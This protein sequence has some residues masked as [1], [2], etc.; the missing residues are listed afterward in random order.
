MA[1]CATTALAGAVPRPCVRGAR[2]RFGGLGPAPGVV[3]PPFPPSRP[4]C[5]ALCV[6][7]RPVRVSLTSLAGNAIARGLCVPRA[8]SGCSSGSP[9][10]PFVCVCAR[11]PAAPVSPPP[12]GCVACAPRAVPVLGAGRAVPRGPCPSACPAPVPCSV[13]RAGEGGRPGPGLP[14]PGLGLCAPR[15]VGLRIRGVAVPLGGVG[16]GG[17][18]PCATPPV[19]AVGGASGA[20]G[21]SASFRPSA[22]PGQATKRATLASFWSWRAWPP[23]RSGSCSP[24]FSGRGLCRVLARWGG[25][26]CSLPFLWEPAAWGGGRR[27][28]LRPLSRAPRSRRGG[29]GS[30]P[31]PREGGRRRPRGLRAGGGAG[32]GGGGRHGPPSLPLGGGP[33][34]PTLPPFSSSAHSPPACA[35]SRGRRAAPC[36]GCG[37][38]GGGGGEEGRP[39]DRSPGGPFRHKTCLCPPQVGNIVGIT[40]D[41]LVMGGAAPIR[42]WCAAACRP[43]AW[44]ARR[45]GA[46]VRA[47][48]SA[49]TP[50][51][52]GGWGRW[53]ARCASP[54]APPPPPRRGTFWGRGG[55]PSAPGGWGVGAPAA[56]KPGG[57]AGGGGGGALPSP[58]PLPRRPAILC[59][60][61]PLPGYTRAVGAAGQLWASGAARW[62]ANG[63]VRGGGGREGG[64]D[65]LTL[66]RAPAFP[67]PASEGAAP[68]APS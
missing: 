68:I 3:S 64:S 55:V 30:S 63:S 9:H 31:L 23:Y 67:R 24:A 27:A 4:G 45:S 34:F 6:A 29:K 22:F 39:V 51:G 1:Q 65:L 35:F 57:G 18:G 8:R 58:A 48:P 59:L 52:A 28:V 62:A 12:L 5:P 19:C 53:V 25:L 54:A 33:R 47:G 61:S 11:A 21:C 49:A 56:L 16:G 38:P 44:S 10:V 7:A 37:L 13:W 32:G 60:R 66:V 36:T 2:G 15:G 43:W 40:G 50:A 14:L 46:L 42:F 41:A 20:G 17:G 26:A